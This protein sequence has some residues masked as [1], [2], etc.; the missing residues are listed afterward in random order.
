MLVVSW[1]FI[2]TFSIL[3]P[4]KFDKMEWNCKNLNISK[5]EKVEP[6]ESFRWNR[7]YFP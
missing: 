5:L 1:R 3:N 6:R 4:K 2:I 7:K